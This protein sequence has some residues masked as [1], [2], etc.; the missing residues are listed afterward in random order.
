M[1]Q[2]EII[3]TAKVITWYLKK[4]NFRDEAFVISSPVFRQ[5]LLDGG[6]KLGEE[7]VSGIKQKPN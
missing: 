5:V 3:T 6:I 4:I 2:E 7:N 1:S